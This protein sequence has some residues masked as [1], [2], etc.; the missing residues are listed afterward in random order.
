VKGVTA[1]MQGRHD[2]ALAVLQD[3]SQRD[4]ANRHLGEEL[5][6]ALCLVALGRLDEAVAPLETVVAFDRPLPDALMQKYRIGGVIQVNVTPLVSATLPI[7][8]GAVALLLA[9]VYQ[10]TGNAE[11][12]IRLLESL[13]SISPDPVFA[14]S[15]ADLYTQTSAWQDVVR[16]SDGLGN[17]DDLT[18]N[19]LCFRSRA[20]R[21]LGINDGA[22]ES[23]RQAL[24]SRSRNPELLR[25]ARYERALAYQ[26]AGRKAMARKDL[27]RILAQDSTFLDVADRLRALRSSP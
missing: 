26:A 13:G 20:F 4:Q 8:G 5:F 3:V 7:V 10:H 24:T 11:R 22:L 9:E 23:A 19:V 12:A 25:L 18:C 6:E 17:V 2:E 27:E 16:V 21:E 1:Y 14:L 15:L